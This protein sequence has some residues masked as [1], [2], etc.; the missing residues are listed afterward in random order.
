MTADE[1]ELDCIIEQTISAFDKQNFINKGVLAKIPQMQYKFLVN[2]K[3]ITS[4][5]LI[6][7]QFFFQNLPKKGHP[8]QSF[9]RAFKFIEITNFRKS[10]MKT[11]S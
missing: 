6:H 2:N 4:W 3:M 11:G 10:A 5:G 1:A 7:L 8:L 9:I